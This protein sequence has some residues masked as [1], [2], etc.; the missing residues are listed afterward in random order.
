MVRL[1]ALVASSRLMWAPAK[2]HSACDRLLDVS[3]HDS[4]MFGIE[5][6][7]VYAECGNP[8]QPFD[9]ISVVGACQNNASVS[10]FDTHCNKDRVAIIQ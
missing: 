7:E 4:L 9:D 8:F 6:L 1:F 5:R 2:H 10:R 3:D